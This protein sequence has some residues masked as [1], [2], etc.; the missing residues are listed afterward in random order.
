MKTNIKLLLFILTGLAGVTA[1]RGQVASN[2][3]YTLDQS[4]IAGGGGTSASAA[5]NQFSV[6]GAI[7]QSITDSSGASPF[8]V[9]SGFFTAPPV[10]APTAAQVTISGQAISSTG[11][12][13]R[14]VIIRLT[15]GNGSVRFATTTTFGYYR[16]TE[17]N[18]GETYIITAKGK[19]YEFAQPTQVLN[20]GEDTYDINF[21]ANPR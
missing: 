18:A 14:N 2:P 10:S 17:V 6:T 8:S 3:P 21:V 11:R 4:V 13:I 7:G 1:T 15:D 9:K 20:I 19:R 12:G 16:F 5:G